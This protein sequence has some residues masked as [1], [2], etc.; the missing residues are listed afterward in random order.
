[1]TKPF[2]MRAPTQ[3]DLA[4]SGSGNVISSIDPV[5]GGVLESARLSNTIGRTKLRT[6]V[7]DGE[8]DGVRSYANV[9]ADGAWTITI[10]PGVPSPLAAPASFS[11]KWGLNTRLVHLE[12]DFTVTYRHAGGGNF[13]VQL[14]PHDGSLFGGESIANEIGRVNDSTEAYGLDGDYYFDVT[15]DGS[16]SIAIAPQG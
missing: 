12:G 13:I 10:R 1:L 16:W 14:T 7:Y 2:T 5:G 11:G 3:V 8:L 6:Y 4:F 9:I 15:A